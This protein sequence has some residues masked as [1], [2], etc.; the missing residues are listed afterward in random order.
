MSTRKHD[1]TDSTTPKPKSRY[2]EAVDKSKARAKNRARTLEGVD[3]SP[4]PGG[5][6]PPDE[7]VDAIEEAKRSPR[8]PSPTPTP[9]T[10]ER[11]SWAKMSAPRR[12]QRLLERYWQELQT[13]PDLGS[14]EAHKIIQAI[15]RLDPEAL[16]TPEPSDEQ[17]LDPALLIDAATHY[18]GLPPD[19]VIKLSG[20]LRRLATSI[21]RITGI[22]PH[23][24][25]HALLELPPQDQVPPPAGPLAPY[26]DEKPPQPS[27]S[28]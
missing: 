17:K 6:P 10:Q 3:L 13:L 8:P 1:P 4:P 11:E 21:A 14:P 25:G 22:D 15:D 27:H 19:R 23:V 2:R 7:Y 5:S 26:D 18:A 16:R 28:A 9:P 24:L 12:R 20:G